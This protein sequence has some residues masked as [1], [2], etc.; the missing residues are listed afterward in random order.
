MK[1][2]NSYLG[3]KIRNI[4]ISLGQ[5]QEEFATAISS[6]TKREIKNKNSI[7]S[8]WEN[9]LNR[10]NA[11]SLKAIADFAGITVDEL[12]DDTCKWKKVDE[13]TGL[14]YKIY[15]YRTDCKQRFDISNLES[16]YSYCPYCG[17][18]IKGISYA[19]KS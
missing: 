17:K 4:R 10:P 6:I 5:N 18:K 8:N 1:R 19:R 15:S 16:K 7:V 13:W 3:E 11:N 9:G 2:N 14:S 12:L